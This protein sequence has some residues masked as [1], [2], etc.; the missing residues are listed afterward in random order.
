[1]G[2]TPKDSWFQ[3]LSF[4]V[5]NFENPSIDIEPGRNGVAFSGFVK[6]HPNEFLLCFHS[7]NRFYI[8]N[9]WF[10]G[11]S[12]RIIIF[13]KYTFCRNYHFFQIARIF[14]IFKVSSCIIYEKITFSIPTICNKP[15][16][17]IIKEYALES[18]LKTGHWSETP[19]IIFW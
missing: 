5:S 7:W 9:F 17:D 4:E 3:Q 13:K 11:N 10:Y 16:V 8:C 6:T 14:T 2:N 18:L 19:C 1:M 15:H 12:K